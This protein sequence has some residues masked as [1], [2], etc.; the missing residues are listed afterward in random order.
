VAYFFGATL[1]VMMMVVVG[2]YE[3]ICNAIL[4]NTRFY[5][6]NLSQFKSTWSQQK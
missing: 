3:N 1:Y 6:D 2:L 5:L 4:G